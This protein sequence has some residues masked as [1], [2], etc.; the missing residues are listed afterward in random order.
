[1]A[2]SQYAGRGQ[3]QNKWQS[4]PGKN[5]TVSLLLKPTFL[6]LNQQFYLNVCISVGILKAIE[7]ILGSK[8]KIKWPND[9]YF[10]DTKIGGILIE[11]QVQ[12]NTIK[13]TIVGIGINVNQTE[14]TADA[15]NAGSIKQI[16]QTDYSILSL[17]AQICNSIDDA[18]LILQN[19][20]FNKLLTLYLQN[21]YWYQQLKPFKANGQVF[22][23]TIT[24]VSPTGQLQVFN[25]QQT[26]EF[27][28][29]EIEFL[30]KPY[31]NP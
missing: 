25:G 26:L 12:G 8:L 4:Q 21:L 23:A 15:P 9:I 18:Y 3:Q 14:F 6:S 27:N 5:L 11:N 19:K 7:N 30:N 24:G 29:K 16:L 31:T 10:N 22:N 28:N 20:N 2:V 13:N 17:L 1:M